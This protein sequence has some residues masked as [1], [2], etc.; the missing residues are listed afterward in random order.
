MVCLRECHNPLSSGRRGRQLHG[1]HRPHGVTCCCQSHWE[2]GVTLFLHDVALQSPALLK[3][4]TCPDRVECHWIVTASLVDLL[5]LCV[6]ERAQYSVLHDGGV[7]SFDTR[8]GEP[9]FDRRLGE[10]HGRALSRVCCTGCHW[11][12]IECTNRGGCCGY[13]YFYMTVCMPYC[14]HT[15]ILCLVV[16]AC[17]A[18]GLLQACYSV[19]CLPAGTGTPG[20]GQC[21]VCGVGWVVL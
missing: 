2:N 15:Q 13:H 9:S 16:E 14:G 8:R 6:C 20:Q 12:C 4:C 19:A 17:S 11:H 3:S 7:S 18:Q 21:L 1:G 10:P 5:C